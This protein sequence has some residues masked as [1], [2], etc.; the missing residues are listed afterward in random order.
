MCNP[1]KL[2]SNIFDNDCPVQSVNIDI[3]D[4]VSNSTDYQSIL[5]NVLNG[6]LQSNSLNINNCQLNSM[7]TTW[8]ITIMIG[9]D[10]LYNEPYFNG[11][12]YFDVNSYPSNTTSFN[13]VIN[14]LEYLKSLGYS[15]TI[16]NDLN[17]I[18]L[19]YKQSCVEFIYGI[20]FKLDIGIN[21]NITCN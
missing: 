6:Y 19:L 18:T 16:S 7:L 9:N 14:G 8:Y 17:N 15:Y 21:F 10:T 13:A 11:V 5:A 2:T 3:S 4:F 20:N 12:G 1:C